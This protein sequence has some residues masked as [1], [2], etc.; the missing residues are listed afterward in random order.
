MKLHKI[1]NKVY[2][3][4]NRN[5]YCRQLHKVIRLGKEAGKKILHFVIHP[6]YLDIGRFAITVEN[7]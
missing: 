3:C 1:M 2:V 4:F 7:L 5:T 6:G